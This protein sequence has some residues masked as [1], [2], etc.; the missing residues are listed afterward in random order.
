MAR[1][2]A[3]INNQVM[4]PYEIEQ[5]IRLPGFSRQT[6]VSGD[7]MSGGAGKWI[8][9]ADIPELA[10]IFQKVDELHDAPVQAPRPAP[11]PK[12]KMPTRLTPVPPPV[13]EPWQFSWGWLW[14]L[15]ISAV[16]GG[17]IYEGYQVMMRQQRAEDFQTARALVE[18]APLPS[19]SLYSTLRQYLQTKQIATRW[20]YERTPT[21]LSHVAVSWP[22]E[23]PGSPLPVYSF[24]VNPQVQSVRGLNSAAIK[25]LAEGF[26]PP[27]SLQKKADTAPQ[28]SPSD[29]FPTRSMSAAKRLNRAISTRCGRLSAAAA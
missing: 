15:L 17:G 2:W 29:E 20:E 7:D 24:E 18:T 4:G 12:S 16:L 19:A 26:P 22:A 9:P 3:Y 6:M 5:L 11:K 25:L 13:E 10:R 1:Y 23:K 28:K 8:S 21:G 14:V 27:L